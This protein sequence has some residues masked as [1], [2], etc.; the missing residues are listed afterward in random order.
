MKITADFPGGNIIVDEIK[1]NNIY[2]HQDLRTTTIDWFYWYFE[3][4]QPSKGEHN[5]SFTKSPAIGV[6]GPAV[7]LDKGRTWNWLGDNKHILN[8]FMYDFT[9]DEESVRFSFAMP[10]QESHLKEFIDANIHNPLFK[11]LELGKTKK[12][13]SID[14]ITLGDIYNSDVIVLTA[15][16]HCC[17]MMASYVLEGVIESILKNSSY[18]QD[19][20]FFIVPFLDKDGVEDGDQGKSRAP[21]DHNRD[22]EDNSIYPSIIALKKRINE[23]GAERFI[24]YIDFHC[25][26]MAGYQNEHIYFVGSESPKIAEAQMEI[27]RM[28]EKTYTILPF[29][30]RGYLPFGESWNVGAGV[31]YQTGSSW[32]T[33]N[34]PNVKLATTI[35]FPYAN[36]LGTPVTQKSAKSFGVKFGNV[37]TSFFQ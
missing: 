22:F 26:Y 23:L 14:L 15:R 8:G 33:N 3:V 2:L 13:R 10:Y 36:A 4:L 17:E 37:I 25:L 20:A 11:H 5:F 7:S 9:G 18:L 30:A 1:D 31:K 12:G 27:G 24:G 32:A 21:H 29:E 34:L 35:E 19:H 6:R 28:L 16:S